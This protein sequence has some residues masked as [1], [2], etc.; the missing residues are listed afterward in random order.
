MIGTPEPREQTRARYPDDEGYVERDGVRV[1]YEVYGDAPTTLLLFPTS[2]ISHSRLWKAQIPYLSRHVRVITFDPRGNGR[3]DRPDSAEAYSSWEFVE[4]GR[5]VLEATRTEVERPLLAAGLS[6]L[7]RVLLLRAASGAPLDQA[8][9]GLCPVGPGRQ[10]RGAGLLGRGGAAAVCEPGGGPRA[11]PP[12]SLPG[13]GRPRRA[14]RLPATRARR[15][16]GRA[17]R[18]DAGRARGRGASPAGAPSREAQPAP[19]RVRGLGRAA[20]AEG[21][22]VDAGAEPPSSHRPCHLRAISSTT[23]PVR[24]GLPRTLTVL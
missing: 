11:V 8:H 15:R 4:D 22:D 21:E 20:A 23:P 5:A 1:F 17:D 3:S 24:H 18:W 9:R 19:A 14:R 7:P 12:R 16:R 2:P 13:A 6:R 10:R